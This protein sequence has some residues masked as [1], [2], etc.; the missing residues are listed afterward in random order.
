M[1]RVGERRCL[2]KNMLYV[3][4]VRLAQAQLG[5]SPVPNKTETREEG[6][7]IHIRYTKCQIRM[8]RAGM[9]WERETA[10]TTFNRDQKHCN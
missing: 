1:Y 7:L 6:M 8:L 10:H 3:V 9:A 4:V 2:L 5:R